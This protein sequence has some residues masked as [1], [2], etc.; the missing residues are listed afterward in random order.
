[1]GYFGEGILEWRAVL[2]MEGHFFFFLLIIFK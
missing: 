2:V 1:M